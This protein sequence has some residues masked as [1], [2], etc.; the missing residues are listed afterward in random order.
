[1]LQV[2]FIFRKAGEV[3]NFTKDKLRLVVSQEIWKMFRTDISCTPAASY[4]H[5]YVMPTFDAKIPLKNVTQ[6]I[7]IYF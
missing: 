6:I 7:K 1:M 4:S 3:F 5:Y 2:Q